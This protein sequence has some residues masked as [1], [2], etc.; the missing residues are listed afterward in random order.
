MVLLP[1]TQPGKLWKHCEL[2]LSVSRDGRNFTRAWD[3]SPVLPVPSSI[4]A[5]DMDYPS[6]SSGVPV[7]IGQELWFYYSDRRH[8]DRPGAG[9]G[10]G[11][12]SI[13]L[14]RLRKDGFASLNAGAASGT[15]RTRPLTF[16]D[17]A[18][19]VN[20]DVLPEGYVKCGLETTWGQAFEPYTLAN[21]QP[22]TKDSRRSP[23]RWHGTA[24]V[25]CPVR[26]SVR[27]VFELKNAKLYSFWFE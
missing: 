1:S 27:L 24:V 5:W 13:G 17:T 10:S 11:Q 14:A 15:V 16:E 22:I 25:R 7:Q 2:Q 20:A 9:P 19:H 6:M 3:R 21:C 23:V 12:R 18:L 8:P 4:E 26:R